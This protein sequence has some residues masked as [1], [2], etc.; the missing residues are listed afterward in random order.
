MKL[1]HDQI[2][3]PQNAAAAG[4]SDRRCGYV[5]CVVC[6]DVFWRDGKRNTQPGHWAVYRHGESGRCSTDVQWTSDEGGLSCKS[7]KGISWPC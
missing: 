7:C 5:R 4:L 6:A 1:A 2:V 3:H